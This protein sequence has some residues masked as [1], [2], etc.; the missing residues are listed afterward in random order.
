MSQRGAAIRGGVLLGALVLVA[1]PAY[2]S[3]PSQICSASKLKATGVKAQGKLKC[4]TKA[5]LKQAAPSAEC[6]ASYE[7]RFSRKWDQAEFAGGCA[8]TGDKNTIE[9]K[10]DS[11]VAD[12]VSAL[13]G[14]PEGSLLGTEA[15]RRCAAAKLKATGK[16]TFSK[17]RCQAKGA[18]I[19]MPADSACLSKAEARFAQRWNLVEG[20]GGCATTGDRDTIE[21]KVDTFVNMA[22][23]MLVPGGTTTSTTTLVT[24]PITTSTLTLPITTTTLT[25]PLTTTTLPLTMTTLTLPLTT[26]T[27]TLPLTTTTLTLPLTT[28]TLTLPLTTTT[29]TLPLT[30]TTLTLPLTTTTLTLPS[31]TTTLTLPPTATT[32]TL[33]PTTTTL[34]VL[35]TTTT[36]TVLPTTTTLTVLPTTTTLTVLHTTTPLPLLA[37]T[38]T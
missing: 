1:G 33:P 13:T 14:S 6:L 8:T 30:T 11:F 10:V 12:V 24:L 23:M 29:L 35:P 15:A 22:V 19:G 9:N 7:S 21:G 34:T 2:A 37:T 20:K 31:T 26:T 16:K 3:S 4:H 27:L 36:L 32:L 5:A 28:T 25:L 38:T 17:L 18:K